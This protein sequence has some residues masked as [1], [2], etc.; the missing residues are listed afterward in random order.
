M[1]FTK[2]IENLEN[3]LKIFRLL[4]KF[5]LLLIK[6]KIFL[7]KLKINLKKFVDNLI[8]TFVYA[9]T[10]YFLNPYSLH[11]RPMPPSTFIVL[12]SGPGRW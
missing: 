12:I 11:F 7:I 3:K 6:F 4:K 8:R 2:F 1:I 9:R 5:Y 10:I